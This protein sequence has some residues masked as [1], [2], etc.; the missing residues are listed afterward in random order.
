M[1]NKNDI[2]WVMCLGYY[3]KSKLGNIIY[4][5]TFEQVKGSVLIENIIIYINLGWKS[6]S[7]NR[8]YCNSSQSWGEINIIKV[9]ILIEIIN[10]VFNL[11]VKLLQ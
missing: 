10:I 11:L 8:N 5:E 7:I 9:S 2:S 3:A 1:N 6:F 4:D